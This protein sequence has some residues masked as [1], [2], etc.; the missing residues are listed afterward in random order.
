MSATFEG[1][2]MVVKENPTKGETLRM[3]MI[4]LE[5]VESFEVINEKMIKVFMSNS[6]SFNLK[7]DHVEFGEMLMEIADGYGKLF[8]F[9]QN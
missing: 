9:N 4:D 8:I 6:E 1:F 3:K 5:K 7:I 2:W